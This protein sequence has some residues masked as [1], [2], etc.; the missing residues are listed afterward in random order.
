MTDIVLKI[1]AFAVVLGLG[2]LW[3]YVK[4]NRSDD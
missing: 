2:A 1:I 3:F 4:G